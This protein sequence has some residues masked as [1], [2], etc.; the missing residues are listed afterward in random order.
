MHPTIGLLAVAFFGWAALALVGLA[1]VAVVVA[2]MRL[3]A[4]LSLLVTD[5]AH[6]RPRAEGGRG[7]VRM[8][9]L[10]V[11]GSSAS[12]AAAVALRVV[13]IV[14]AGFCWVAGRQVYGR[15]QGSLLIDEM[16]L[17]SHDQ[18]TCPPRRITT[19]QNSAL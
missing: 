18:S 10:L 14:L 1:V 16:D 7:V 5:M 15:D 4:S 12:L 19:L 11:T 3:Q 17:R 2:L 13:I 6:L 9:P 8:R